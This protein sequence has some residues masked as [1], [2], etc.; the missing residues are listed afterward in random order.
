MIDT[1]CA[2]NFFES[3]FGEGSFPDRE[4]DGSAVLFVRWIWRMM[5][6]SGGEGFF[7]DI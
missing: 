1:N 3:V 7:T 2:G 5:G 4:K 6:K